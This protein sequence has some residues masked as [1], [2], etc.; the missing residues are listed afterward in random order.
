MVMVSI[1]GER[2]GRNKAYR[3]VRV[4]C[5]TLPTVEK[6]QREIVLPLN[7]TQQRRR[8]ASCILNL[9]AIRSGSDTGRFE[10]LSAAGPRYP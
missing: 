3:M 4:L 1:S 9:L 5:T 6:N 10:E 8:L 2:N 7:V